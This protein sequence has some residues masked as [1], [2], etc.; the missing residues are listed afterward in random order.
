MNVVSIGE[1]TLTTYLHRANCF[2]VF[3]YILWQCLLLVDLL[4]F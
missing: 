2:K 3:L 4:Y 1:I